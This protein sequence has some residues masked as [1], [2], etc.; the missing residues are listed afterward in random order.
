MDDIKVYLRDMQSGEWISY[1]PEDWIKQY[2]ARI[3]D[4]LVVHQGT[5]GGSIGLTGTPERGRLT[6]CDAGDKVVLDFDWHTMTVETARRS[7]R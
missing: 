3:E 1:A 2:Y 4:A 7:G 6:V 5:F